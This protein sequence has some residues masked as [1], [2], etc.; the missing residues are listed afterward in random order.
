MVNGA[1]SIWNVENIRA[2]GSTINII[3]KYNLIFG[4]GKMWRKFSANKIQ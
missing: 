1:W 2:H 3:Y 4:D